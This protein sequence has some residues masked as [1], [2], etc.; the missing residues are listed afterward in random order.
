V[1]TTAA[2]PEGKLYAMIEK[3]ETYEIEPKGCDYS[4][5]IKKMSEGK[6][7]FPQIDSKSETAYT[8]RFDSKSE[9]A[10]T[11]RCGSLVAG[12]PGKRAIVTDGRLFWM[13]CNGLWYELVKANPEREFWSNLVAMKRNR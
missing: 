8:F 12:W 13:A 11:F 9:T 6:W 3:K 7:M 5:A 1:R 4:T 2:R 10:Y